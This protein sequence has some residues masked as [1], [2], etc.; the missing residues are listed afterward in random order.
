MIFFLTPFVVLFCFVFLIE[1][2]FTYSEI[3][4]SLMSGSVIFDKHIT[5]SSKIGNI[6]I[7]PES[8]VVSLP[9]TPTPEVPLFSFLSPA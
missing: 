7:A 9:V 2:K 4:L 5:M 6:S 8:S 1:A 3:Y